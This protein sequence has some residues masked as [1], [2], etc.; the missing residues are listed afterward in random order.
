M[1]AVL[2]SR[3]A[4]VGFLVLLVGLI[5]G[6]ALLWVARDVDESA[7]ERARVELEGRI[8]SV[9]DRARRRLVT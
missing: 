1:P 5:A 2:T 8:N 6:A 9:T 4:S 7:V 3:L